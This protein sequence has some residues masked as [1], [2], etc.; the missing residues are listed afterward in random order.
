M[1]RW[2]FL[3]S[4]SSPSYLAKIFAQPNLA[5][6]KADAL[7]HNISLFSH[8]MALTNQKAGALEML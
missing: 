4:Y 7:E 2:P 1:L 6:Q 5:E 3:L 8:K